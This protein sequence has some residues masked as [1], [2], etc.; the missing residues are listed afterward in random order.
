M[1]RISQRLMNTFRRQAALVDDELKEHLQQFAARLSG[2]APAVQRLLEDGYD[3]LHVEYILGHEF[4][5]MFSNAMLEYAEFDEYFDVL[6]EAEGRYVADLDETTPVTGSCFSLWSLFDL[7]FGVD[8]ET[9]GGCLVDVLAAMQA[10]PRVLRLLRGLSESR[11]GVYQHQGAEGSLVRLRELVTGQ[12]LCCFST[13]GHAGRPGELWFVRLGAPLSDRHD[14]HV[15]LTTPYVLTEAT[16]DDWTAYLNKSLLGGGPGE[17]Q[18]V[19]ELLKFGKPRAAWLDFI[20]RAY[21]Y[22]DSY[23]VYLAGLPDVPSSLPNAACV[24]ALQGEG[25]RPSTRLAQEYVPLALTGAQRAALA[26][27]LPE[28]EVPVTKTSHRSALLSLARLFLHRAESRAPAIMGP[29]KGAQRKPYQRL[30]E[31]A[32]SDRLVATGQ[33]GYRLRI[34]LNYAEPPI[35]RA[36]ETYDCTLVDLH[37]LIQAVMGWEGDHLFEFE[38]NGLK[39]ST[40]SD[41]GLMDSDR[42]GDAE[43]TYLSQIVPAGHKNASFSYMYDFGDSWVH[44]ITVDAIVPVD[45]KTTYPR[46]VSGTGACPPEDCGGMYQYRYLVE[47]LAHPDEEAYDEAIGWLGESADP[48]AFDVKKATRLMHRVAARNKK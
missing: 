2:S 40:L 30:L 23:A 5:L 22:A 41:D 48:T 15:T 14:C 33:A 44:T 38:A 47:A 31:I 42:L 45:K 21:Q 7:R 32:A 35:W 36:I 28:L 25:A 1:G 4:V 19:H 39:Y 24:E 29:L 26:A 11:L 27:L 6:A 17:P 12:E 37:F 18:N 46:C 8:G 9:M 20:V 16:V 13:S 43:A 34:E 3:P 10:D